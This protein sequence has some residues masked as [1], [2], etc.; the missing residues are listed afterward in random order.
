MRHSVPTGNGKKFIK[1]KAV[2][3][4]DLNGLKTKELIENQLTL[5][6]LY[7]LMIKTGGELPSA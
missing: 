3:I 1:R 7:Y 4:K 5:D 6:K 2:Q